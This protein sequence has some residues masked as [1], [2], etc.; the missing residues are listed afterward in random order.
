M[1]WGGQGKKCSLRWGWE[2]SQRLDPQRNLYDIVRYF[3]F[4]SPK[5]KQCTTAADNA[6]SVTGSHFMN[7][8]ALEW[9][10]M[11]EKL[12]PRQVSLNK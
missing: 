3:D 7:N 4:V 12:P 6:K 9:L 5:A 10:K 2:K 8:S 1:D 11:Q